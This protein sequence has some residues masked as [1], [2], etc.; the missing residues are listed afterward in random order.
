MKSL[1]KGHNKPG[2]K[3]KGLLESLITYIQYIVAET[4]VHVNWGIMYLDGK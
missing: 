1:L 4:C 3:D 2:K